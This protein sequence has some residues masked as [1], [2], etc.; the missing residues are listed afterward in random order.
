MLRAEVLLL[1]E[2]RVAR[3]GPHIIGGAKSIIFPRS[4]PVGK[5]RT[6]VNQLDKG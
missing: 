5:A 3:L 1:V 2:V 6:L 4:C